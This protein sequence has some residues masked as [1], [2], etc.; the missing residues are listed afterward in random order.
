M[1]ERLWRPI[2]SVATVLLLDGLHLDE[3]AHLLELST[4]RRGILL[5]HLVLVVLEA[6]R[7]ERAVHPPR[8]PDAAPDLPD[9]HLARGQLVLRR[10]LWPP[11]GV[12]HE[13]TRHCLHRLL[14]L[15]A[16]A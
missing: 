16:R 7:L 13:S 11:T 14:R 6:D 12:P 5:D 10:L 9:A 8:V 3:V 4:Q 2:F 1:G 15:G